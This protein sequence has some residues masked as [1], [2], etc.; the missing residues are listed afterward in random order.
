M[1]KRGALGPGCR[2]NGNMCEVG[3]KN[4]DILYGDKEISCVKDVTKRVA[5]AG[6]IWVG[7]LMNLKLSHNLAGRSW[8]PP[9]AL[10]VKMG[11]VGPLFKLFL[12]NVDS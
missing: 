3:K 12:N 5:W 9:T 11:C 2:V 4:C 8:L 7:Q 1:V 6:N 10:G